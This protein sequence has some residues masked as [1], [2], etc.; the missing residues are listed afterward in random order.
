LLSHT[1]TDPGYPQR[2][3]ATM[4][5]RDVHTPGRRG[6][7][8]TCAEVTLEFPKH[9]GNPVFLHIRQSHPIN[10]SGTFV[11]PDPLP[12][13]PQ[14]VTSVDTVEQ[15]METPLRRLLGRSP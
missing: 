5:F 8:H 1:I 10:S 14:H 3:L 12:R 9:P 2:T 4:W 15:S 11:G 6:T 7:I 13:L